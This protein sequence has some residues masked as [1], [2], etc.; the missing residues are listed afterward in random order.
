MTL[1]IVIEQSHRHGGVS[2]LWRCGLSLLLI[3]YVRGIN[4][5]EP[6]VT[7][8]LSP[9]V[10]GLVANA[11][12]NLETVIFLEVASRIVC[13]VIWVLWQ[14]SDGLGISRQVLRHLR[15]QK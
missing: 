3:E 7:L 10:I 6:T 8:V 14:D 9:V 13:G 15:H 1:C 4:R 12:L 11:V 2:S 5:I